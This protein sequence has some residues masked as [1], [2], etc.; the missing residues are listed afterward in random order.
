MQRQRIFR[1]G[2][3]AGLLFC[4]AFAAHADE[5][6]NSPA[7]PSAGSP[8]PASAPASGEPSARLAVPPYRSPLHGFP[9]YRADEPLRD[10]REVNDEVGRLGGHVGHLRGQLRGQSRESGEREAGR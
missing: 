1:R 9:P 6:A 8:P 2:G 10:W 3:G 7:A 4:L 5:A